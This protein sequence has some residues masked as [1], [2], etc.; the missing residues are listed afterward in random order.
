MWYYQGKPFETLDQLRSC[1]NY[2][3]PEKIIGF[4]YKITNLT[5]GA[6]YIGKKS[7]KSVQKKKLNRKELSSDKRKRN[8]KVV[9]SE[10]D[11]KKYYGS[12]KQLTEDVQKL[13]KDC[14]LREILEFACTKKYLGYLE[15]KYQFR[16]DVLNQQSYNGNILGRYFH[17]DLECLCS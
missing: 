13:G 9:V 1:L 15:L 17:K 4:C 10:S 11:W 7:V 2:N 6:I 14:F 12:S 3:H 16:F 8:Y 5:T